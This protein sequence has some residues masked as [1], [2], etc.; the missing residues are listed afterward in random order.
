LEN[1]V[2]TPLASLI[3]RL[4]GEHGLLWRFA[5]ILAA[6]DPKNAAAKT[7]CQR[8]REGR[9]AEMDAEDYCAAVQAIH[10]ALTHQDLKPLSADVLREVDENLNEDARPAHD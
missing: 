7:A 5:P 9:V 8:S 10:K 3:E 6:S 1:R 4:E 2:R